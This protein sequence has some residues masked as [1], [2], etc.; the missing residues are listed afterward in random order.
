MWLALANGASAAW[1]KQK[2]N[3][4][5]HTGAC[6]AFFY[7]PLGTYLP[8]G[9]EAQTIW[10]RPVEEN[11]GSGSTT[12]AELPADS[13]HPT[14]QPHEPAL[15]NVALSAIKWSPHP[16]DTNLCMKWEWIFPTHLC[17]DGRIVSKGMIAVVLSHNG[18]WL[19]VTRPADRPH[20]FSE[21]S[22]PSTWVCKNSCWGLHRVSSRDSSAFNL[23]QVRQ[24]NC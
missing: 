4:C 8:S 13:Q 10:E 20:S 14:C 2:L 6:L 21:E 5:L 7:I 17:S 22:G 19:V 18:R 23:I 3:D 12:L 9:R 16:P 24:R 11:G 1:N 15:L